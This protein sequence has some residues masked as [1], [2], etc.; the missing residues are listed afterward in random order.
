MA[1]SLIDHPALW[2]LAEDSAAQRQYLRPV[3]LCC[4][5]TLQQLLRC[6][7][8]R[9]SGLVRKTC[10]ALFRDVKQRHLQKLDRTN[11]NRLRATLP[12]AKPSS[13]LPN[14][15]IPQRS[16]NTLV[17]SRGFFETFRATVISG[18]IVRIDHSCFRPIH[19]RSR[20]TEI[21]AQCIAQ[22][23][24]T[25]IREAHRVRDV[26]SVGHPQF[27]RARGRS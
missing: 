24:R 1:S 12:Y 9:S 20:N 26:R 11:S 16:L 25:T 14:G 3:H 27:F 4:A 18:C 7:L 21:N 17:P 19:R 10:G 13:R 22:K 2:R 23:T 5:R 6:I 8:P 15:I